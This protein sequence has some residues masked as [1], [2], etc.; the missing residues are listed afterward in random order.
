MKNL[1]KL[2][3]GVLFIGIMACN[4]QEDDKLTLGTPPTDISFDIIS[5][6]HP[7]Y[8]TL[9]NTTEGTFIHKWDLGNGTTAEGTEVEG[10]FPQ[11]GDY[12]I[13]LLAFNDGGYAETSKTLTILEDD[14]DAC[15]VDPFM[16]FLTNCDT[17]TWMMIPE[18]AAYWVGPHDGSSTWW[19]S[20]QADVDQRPCAF[21]DEWIFSPDGIMVYD[22]KGDLWAEDYMGFSFECILDSQLN[23]G[24]ETWGSGTHAFAVIPGTPVQLAVSGLGAFIGLPK[25][26]NGSEVTSPQSNITYDV[27]NYEEQVNRYFMELQI[28]MGAGFWRFKLISP[29]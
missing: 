9:K 12:T 10:Y 22:T 26:A 2:L 14:P 4:P 8:F 1:N 11:K 25:V 24:Q 19:E 29:K 16:E 3:L 7:N 27:I 20:G 17:R 21:N 23:P 18:P 5:T 6:D 15:L 13:N 28:D